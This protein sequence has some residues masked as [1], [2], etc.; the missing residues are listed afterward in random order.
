MTAERNNTI[1]AVLVGG[2][3]ARMGRAK[4]A[5]VLPGGETLL[6]HALQIATEFAVERWV[7]GGT[8]NELPVRDV[9][10]LAD[11]APGEGPLAAAAT[12]LSR[13]SLEWVLLLACDVPQLTRGV[14]EALREAARDDVDVVMA[15]GRADDRPNPLVAYYRTRIGLRMREAVIG[16]E[17]SLMRFL[18]RM[19][20]Q[21]VTVD[22]PASLV[23]V[24]TP[25]D[26]EAFLAAAQGQGGA[27]KEASEDAS[28]N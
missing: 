26:W 22:S 28:D 10:H 3:S 21:V 9:M 13:A 14:V 15:R 27:M 6:A 20:T 7:A 8:A 5:L 19:T 24:N 25:A 4:A 11:D 23:S 16:G 2:R 17:R 1:A 18:A 12:V